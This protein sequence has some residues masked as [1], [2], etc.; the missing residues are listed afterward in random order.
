MR[1]KLNK[2]IYPFHGV[3][4]KQLKPSGP[5]ENK[6]EVFQFKKFSLKIASISLVSV[7]VSFSLSSVGNTIS[8]FNDV[9]QTIGNFLRADPIGF[10]VEIDSADSAQVDLSLG[11]VVV[12]PIMTPNSDSEP[13]QYFVKAEMING[14]SELCNTI[15]LFATY[16]F[17]YDGGLV[18]L[19]TGTTTEVGPWTMAL[20]VP[21]YTMFSDKS[22]TV[23]LVYKGWNSGV[24]FGKG[25]RDTQKVSI[26]F[27]VPYIPPPVVESLVVPAIVEDVLPTVEG[28]TLEKQ[29]EPVIKE[30]E[31]SPEPVA[32]TEPGVSVVETIEVPPDPV[33]EVAEETPVLNEVV[34]PVIPE[35]NPEPSPPPTEVTP[36]LEVT[37]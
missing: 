2:E 36:P 4:R 14:D 11:E 6:T 8:Y 17:P 32:V 26:T 27:I 30:T 21:D 19:N 23:E 31:P 15:H 34:L 13:I 20:S 9:E 33:I 24:P 28:T 16:P 29:P 37:I 35:P 3:R 18:S 5:E 7:L 12:T 22:C 25:Y 1:S 10:E